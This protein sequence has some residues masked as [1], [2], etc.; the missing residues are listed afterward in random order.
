MRRQVLTSIDSCSCNFGFFLV[1]HV[2]LR[3]DEH[4]KVEGKMSMKK[5][6]EV[7]IV[8]E[9]LVVKHAHCSAM[10]LF[11]GLAEIVDAFVYVILLIPTFA[12]DD[13]MYTDMVSF[14][15]LTQR[16]SLDSETRAVARKLFE[17][18]RHYRADSVVS[19]YEA[20]LVHPPSK[21]RKVSSTVTLDKGDSG[22]TG[23]LFEKFFTLQKE[24][25]HAM[26]LAM[27]INLQPILRKKES[28]SELLSLLCM[29]A[30][31]LTSKRYTIKYK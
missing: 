19:V 1:L 9:V 4:S 25:F 2:T 26:F 22:G 18:I 21:R 11:I 20:E 12:L 14:Q 13:E 16:I 27:N 5:S 17:D 24:L 29:W 3:C 10:Q 6:S 23:G 30:D 7:R 28:R 8:Y 15:P 31:F